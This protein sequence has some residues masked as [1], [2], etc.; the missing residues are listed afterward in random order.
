MSKAKFKY[1]E[2]L[3]SLLGTW[4]ENMDI[5]KSDRSSLTLNG[6]L[7]FSVNDTEVIAPIRI[8][9]NLRTMR[10]TPPMLFC[11][12]PWVKREADWHVNV[13]ADGDLCWISHDEWKLAQ[14]QTSKSKILVVEDFS[15]LLRC[16]ALFLISR[17]WIATKLELKIWP[18][19]W[20]QWLHSDEGTKQFWDEIKTE[21][22]PLTW[23]TAKT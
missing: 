6:K 11:D 18:K 23:M 9:I 12:E 21:G 20:D 4:I 22:K 5:Q 14:S 13:N 17:H 8:K 2:N 3:I 7:R 19:Q 10:R 1:S 16:G 15:E